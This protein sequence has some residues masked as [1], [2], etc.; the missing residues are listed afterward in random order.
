VVAA[1]FA[2]G[3]AWAW[4]HYR[5]FHLDDA[6][7]AFRYAR[8]L[9]TG[10]GWVYNQGEAVNGATSPLHVMILALLRLLGWSEAQ[11]AQVL[12]VVCLAACA[13]FLYLHLRQ[14][15]C[16][17]A[18]ALSGLLLLT[19]P[20]VLATSGM[21]TMLYLGL[22]MAAI[23][24][25]HAG[26]LLLPG[27]ALG[28][29]VLTR[30]DGI[31][32][33][34]VVLGHR[35]ITARRFP[36]A[37]GG[38]A[39]ILALPWY[40]FAT[41]RFGAPWPNTLG[42]KLAQ[43]ASGDW[44]SFAP[45]IIA[46]TRMYLQVSLV[47][48]VVLEGATVGLVA[49]AWRARSHVTLPV[50]AGVHLLAY[51]LLAVPSYQ[52]YYAP[53]ALAAV[54]LCAA[55][56]L[57]LRGSSR[58]WAIGPA[59]LMAGVFLPVLVAHVTAVPE[60]LPGTRQERIGAYRDVGRWLSKNTPRRASV[61]TREVGVIGY[62]SDRVILDYL[63]LVTPASSRVARRE[64]TWWLRAHRPD[65]VV[66]WSPPIAQEETIVHDPDFVR[67]YRPLKMLRWPDRRAMI[68]YQR[69]DA[70]SRPPPSPR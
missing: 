6:Y 43:S 37:L 3:A 9:A 70:P 64:Y 60:S 30:P 45:G 65:Y 68:V 40:L 29:L 28:L 69:E 10:H 7:I 22:A 53:A 44:T 14:S 20:F 41:A 25:Y 4:S 62:Y 35:L 5:H 16:P 8:N 49:I 38:L 11:S 46:W 23:Y 61:A 50:W 13:W 42:A 31:L 58:P 59:A 1:L 2:L 36:L 56:G 21:E 52:W 55:W 34:A 12:G 39:L 54:F 15:D 51:S 17:P 19:S 63:G 27:A 57:W 32:L 47:Y 48:L 67:N 18:G 33:C 66:T 26:R 24:W